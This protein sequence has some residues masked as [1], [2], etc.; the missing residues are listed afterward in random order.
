MTDVV[1]RTAVEPN[2]SKNIGRDVTTY[3]NYSGCTKM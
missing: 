2:G 3:N 1:Q